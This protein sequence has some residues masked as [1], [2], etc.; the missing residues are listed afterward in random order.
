MSWIPIMRNLFSRKSVTKKD[1][2]T[3]LLVSLIFLLFSS[4]CVEEFFSRTLLGQSL[5][6]G[7]TVISMSIGVW[8]IKSNKFAFKSGLGLLLGTIIISTLVAILDKIELEYLHLLFM[9]IFFVTT[10]KIAS[11]QVLFSGEIT[12]NSIIGSICIFLLLG[13]IWTIVYLLIDEFLPHSFSGLSE[14][15]WQGNFP[16]LLYF[17]FIT[18]TTLG[19]GDIVPTGS[20]AKFWVYSEAIVGVFYMAII[21]SSLVG[22]GLNNHG[23]KIL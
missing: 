13:L 6:L 2:F 19:F 1:N 3:Y 16:D 23:K 4:A 11:Q 18:I 15:N 5:V 17:S 12:K 8:S 22:A 9:L 20:I 7:L 21:V 14:T 10:L